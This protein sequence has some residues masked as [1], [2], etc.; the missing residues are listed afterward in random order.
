MNQIFR[1]LLFFVLD[2]SIAAAITLSKSPIVFAFFVIAIPFTVLI[3]YLFRKPISSKNANFR[4]E[5]EKTQGAVNEMLDMVSVTRAHGLQENAITK[6]NY[7]LNGIVNKGYQLDLI[8]SLFGAVSWVFFQIFQ[9]VCLAFT[10]YLAYIGKITIGE[11]IL[12]QTYFTQLVG[13]I[14]TLLNTRK[15]FQRRQ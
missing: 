9:I 5:V 14:A 2:F 6:M 13:Q 10:G 11:V 7:H 12:F 15:G 8:N 1:T 3:L 4:K